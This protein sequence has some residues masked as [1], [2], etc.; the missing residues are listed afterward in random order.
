M[1]QCGATVGLASRQV[2]LTLCLDQRAEVSQERVL[3][4]GT[5]DD[6]LNR[7][8]YETSRSSTRPT[9]LSVNG[10]A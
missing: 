3:P 10:S 7:G 4:A 1:R 2:R 5:A 9:P 6:V 8:V